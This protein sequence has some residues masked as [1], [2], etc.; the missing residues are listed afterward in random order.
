MRAA[1]HGHKEIIKE[2]LASGA[3]LSLKSKAGKTAA[4]FTKS[5][6]IKKMLAAA[7]PASAAATPVSDL[8]PAAAAPAPTP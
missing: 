8:A 2:L 7:A 1:Y 5:V 4:D 6:Q 3:N